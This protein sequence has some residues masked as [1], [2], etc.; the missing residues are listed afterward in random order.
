[1]KRGIVKKDLVIIEKE[2]GLIEK[3][4]W[5]LIFHFPYR[6]L[7]LL[8]I[9]AI[10]AYIL[11]RNSNVQGFV[12]SLGKLEY[13]GIF[14][15]GM[16]FTFGFTTPFAIGFFIIL[17]PIN[18]FLTAIIGGLGA[19]LG[20]LLIFSVIRFTFIDEF[21]RLEKTRVI[22]GIRNEIKMHFSHKARLYILYALAGILI[23]SPLPDEAGVIML[24]GLTHI[25]VSKMAIISFI[26]NTIGIL[27]M[28]LI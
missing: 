25:K 11:F 4:I 6:K 19:L 16:L 15:A 1:M 2:F 20:D 10:F 18:P 28:C 9:L 27:I 5:K 12:S 23:A 22:R 24:A 26:F 13:L 14:I 21:K 17:D 7:L 8:L 3:K